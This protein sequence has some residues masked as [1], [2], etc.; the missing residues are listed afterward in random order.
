MDNKFYYVEKITAVI[1]RIKDWK[2]QQRD[3]VELKRAALLKV[4]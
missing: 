2:S 3:R 1:I 4:L